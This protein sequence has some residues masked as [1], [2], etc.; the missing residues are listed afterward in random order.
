[1]RRKSCQDPILRLARL[2]VVVSWCLGL[3]AASVF[4]QDFSKGFNLYLPL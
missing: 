2:A 3:V 4:S 1:M